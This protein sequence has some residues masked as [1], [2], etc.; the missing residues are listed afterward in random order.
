MLKG[1]KVLG[2]CLAATFLA[3]LGFIALSTAVVEAMR[4]ISPPATRGQ[5]KDWMLGTPQPV[6]GGR[7]RRDNG[8]V[9]AGVGVGWE[10]YVHP[11]DPSGPEGVPFK[12]RT[13]LKCVFRDPLY[14]SHTGVDFSEVV[15]TPVI[16]T[17]AGLVVWVGDNG[18]WGGLVVVENNGIQIY[19]AHLSA[20]SV[21]RGDVVERGQKIGE[22]GNTGNST[23]PHLHYGI[24]K[25]TG[26]NSYVWVDPQNYFY[27]G[28]KK[29]A[30]P[31][32]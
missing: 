8:A 15:G 5:I 29:A 32:E 26:D 23:G 25:K 20:F 24:K 11:T 27:D 21:A 7:E 19:Y 1:V 16:T 4:S 30:C 3:V 14:Q 28:Y 9:N 2:G 6:A 12:K 10:D 31:T 13:V 17:M 22:V 18:P